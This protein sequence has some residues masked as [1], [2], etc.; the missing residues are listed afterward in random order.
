MNLDPTTATVDDF[1]AHFRTIAAPSG[2]DA[3]WSGYRFQEISARRSLTNYP[4]EWPSITFCL[5]GRYSEHF[6]GPTLLD[7]C[8]NAY[9]LLA[10]K[11]REET[12]S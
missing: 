4:S 11:P 5:D 8:R 7:A 2:V 10:F 3:D 1:L 6:H 9:K 12:A